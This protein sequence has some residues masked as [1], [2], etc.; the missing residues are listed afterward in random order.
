MVSKYIEWLVPEVLKQ[1][2]QVG[3]RAR[4]LVIFSLI[5]PLFFVP[6]I[7]K[8][9]KIGSM[10]LAVSM[11]MVMV[12]VTLVAPFVMRWSGSALIAGNAIM[13]ALAWH[14]T[15]LPY[16][17]G[18]L[19]SS[20]M[21]WNLVLPIFAAT[22]VSFRSMI[23]WSGVMLLEILVFILLHHQGFDLPAVSMSEPQMFETQVAN[24]IGPFCALIITL[25]FNERGFQ[26][27]FS[28]QRETQRAALDEQNQAQREI[29]KMALNLRQTFDKVRAS[30]GDLAKIS[31][32][33]AGMAKDNVG[34][35]EE[36]DKVMKESEG[37]VQQA[38]RSMAELTVSM[39]EI[40]IA[41]RETS[42]IM[43][44]IDEIAFQTNL[45]ALNAAV[46]AARAG[47]AGAGFAVV[48]GEVRNLA[49]KSAESAQNTAGLI[50]NTMQKIDGGNQLVS[51][52]SGKIS[53]LLERV[54]KVVDLMGKIAGCSAD[55]AKGVEG[56]RRSVED[57]N[58]LVDVGNFEENSNRQE[59]Y[60]QIT[61]ISQML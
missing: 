27:L 10:E 59:S 18:G 58:R 17:T 40:S 24:A 52:T 53:D 20:A 57:L 51:Q 16:C 49:M 11:L 3:R 41:S 36:A 22:F 47:E 46:E 7:I 35:A 5:A 56:I 61:Q 28:I 4:Q 54:G 9:Y 26:H 21:T 30:S 39:N 33:I 55:Q 12:V 23:F 42:K 14:F 29:E 32:G 13:V 8:W 6:N 34:S 15:F 48:A 38:N 43:R 31:E 50:E 60:P 37:M 45:L 2:P 19:L 25:F 1:D 44:T